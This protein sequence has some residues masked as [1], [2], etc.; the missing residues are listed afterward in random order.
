MRIWWKAFCA[1]SCLGLLNVLGAV[2]AS[3]QTWTI[4]DHTVAMKSNESIDVT[5]IYWTAGNCRSFLT[6]TPEV[7]ILDGP[8]QVTASIR[9]TTVLPRHYNCANRIAGGML[10]LTSKDIEDPSHTLVTL[11]ITYKTL[12]GERKK[13]E[14]IQL[15]LIP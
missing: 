6:A 4:R 11:R 9:A 7:E 10:V 1:V 14:V 15:S 5:K 12:E 13:S 8:P 2:N 3:A